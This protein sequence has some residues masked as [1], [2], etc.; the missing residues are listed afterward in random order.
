MTD[1]APASDS[2][3]KG[4]RFH[5]FRPNPGSVVIETDARYAEAALMAIFGLPVAVPIVW[6]ITHPASEK[7]LIGLVIADGSFTAFAAYFLIMGAFATLPLM[8]TVGFWQCA[9]RRRFVFSDE[10]LHFRG[11]PGA[12]CSVRL[13]NIQAVV[14]FAHRIR[15]TWTCNVALQIKRDSKDFLLCISS[16]PICGPDE[17]TAFQDQADKMI[18]I[19]RPV[20]ELL[21]QVTDRPILIEHGK[22]LRSILRSFHRLWP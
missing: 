4:F 18:E 12:N 21:S 8:A 20:A 14:I 17:C 9:F 10:M 22:G 16:H 3:L 13:E 15:S 1:Q 11:A 5:A 2:L 19:H 6:D 7:S